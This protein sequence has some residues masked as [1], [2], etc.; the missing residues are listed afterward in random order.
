MRL[1][2]R[3][4]KPGAL[5]CVFTDWR[6]LPATTDALQMAG[7]VWRGV[8]VW[9]KGEGTRPR[10]FGFRAQCEFVV[11]G[12]AGPMRDGPDPP[13]AAGSFRGATRPADKLHIAQK[14]EGVMAWLM[15]TLVAGDTVLDP[16]V[17]SGTT[18]LA[19]RARGVRSVG[20]ELQPEWCAIAADRLRQGLLL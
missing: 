20:F 8:A 9:D 19:A 11:W 14:P 12:T 4:A 17:G 1:A 16:F 2:Y 3:F 13:Y 15:S 18:L 5:A 6:Q 10:A 7:W